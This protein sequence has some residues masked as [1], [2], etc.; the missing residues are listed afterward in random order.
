[1][2]DL[3][4]DLR[5][6]ADYWQ[7]A[8]KFSQSLEA[9]TSTTPNSPCDSSAMRGSNDSE[10]VLN[11]EDFSPQQLDHTPECCYSQTK[12]AQDSAPGTLYAYGR[13]K[14]S[15]RIPL[16]HLQ[17]AFSPYARLKGTLESVPLKTSHYPRH[18][19][20][21]GARLTFLTCYTLPA[22]L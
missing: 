7:R 12:M 22:M 4:P 20:T 16:P 19:R 5:T 18:C 3:L 21:H 9:N 1:M 15:N 11:L 6:R 14:G 17:P 13:V 2:A 10:D 8:A